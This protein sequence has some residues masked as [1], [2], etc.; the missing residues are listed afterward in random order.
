MGDPTLFPRLLY[1]ELVATR[2][3]WLKVARR[4]WKAG[5][6]D[7]S[8]ERDGMV[9]PSDLPVDIVLERG[10]FGTGV[11]RNEPLWRLYWTSK[12]YSMVYKGQINIEAEQRAA[13]LLLS[14]MEHLWFTVGML[15]C[16]AADLPRPSKS[17]GKDLAYYNGLLGRFVNWLPEIIALRGSFATETFTSA[18]FGRVSPMSWAGNF[19]GWACRAGYQIPQFSDDQ[20]DW[21]EFVRI[22]YNGDVVAWFVDLGII[23]KRGDRFVLRQMG[24]EKRTRE[25]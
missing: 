17:H 7:D 20:F 15:C 2:K 24:E 22:H 23:Q 10:Y 3:A 14:G 16:E 5:E 21:T 9:R 1:G 25:I 11:R 8:F 4:A 19:V 12:S 18:A 13:H 6:W